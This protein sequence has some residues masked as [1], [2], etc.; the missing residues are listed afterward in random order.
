MFGL[1]VWRFCFRLLDFFCLDSGV[2]GTEQ[3]KVMQSV[4]SRNIRNS[5]KHKI[6]NLV[7]IQNNFFYLHLV[8]NEDLEALSSKGKV[9]ASDHASPFSLDWIA[10]SYRG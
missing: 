2:R 5:T 8:A 9:E 3:L 7:S 1:L 6:L 4:L 10:S